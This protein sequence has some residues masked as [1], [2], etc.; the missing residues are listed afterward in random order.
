MKSF[1]D[2]PFRGQGLTYHALYDDISLNVV[3]TFDIS[4]VDFNIKTD[5][6]RF[7]ANAGITNQ[8]T[9]AI[10]LGFASGQT[11]NQ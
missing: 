7:G 11:I 6:V 1:L 5:Q 9:K 2:G 10:A 4:A 3:K 8:Q